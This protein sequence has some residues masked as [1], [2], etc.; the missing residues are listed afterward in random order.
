MEPNENVET[1]VQTDPRQPDPHNPWWMPSFTHSVEFADGSKLNG[2]ASLNEETK[3]LWVWLD[4]GVLM[5][6][7]FVIFSDPS[8][9]SVIISHTTSISNFTF[10]G[11]TTLSLIKMDSGKVTVRMRKPEEG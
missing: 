2:A 11:Y 9:T 3:E 10:E 7:A 1:E 5:T 8:K 6:D 4:E